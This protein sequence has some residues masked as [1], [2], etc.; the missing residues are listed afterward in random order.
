[1]WSSTQKIWIG[2]LLTGV[3]GCSYPSRVSAQDAPNSVELLRGFAE[4]QATPGGPAP[5][6]SKLLGIFVDRADYPAATI[7]SLMDGLE[8]LALSKANVNARRAA[9][10]HLAY[11]SRWQDAKPEPGMFARFKRVYDRTDS[12]EIR[13]VV[14]L[15]M[16]GIAERPQSV[17]FLDKIARQDP[18]AEEFPNAALWALRS[19]P[20]AGDEG[21]AELK[22]LHESNAVVHPEARYGLAELAKKGYKTQ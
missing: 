8:D 3:Y 1:M 13:A 12:G 14:V 16:G 20:G 11:V 9:V 21:R 7:R 18:A 17:A 2:I 10:I 15:S 22:L 4:E 5:A 6:T 19:L